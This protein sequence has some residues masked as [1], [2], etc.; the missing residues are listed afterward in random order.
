MKV[1]VSYFSGAVIIKYY[2]PEKLL[3]GR[4]CFGLWL[5]RVRVHHGAESV[6]NYKLQES[7]LNTEST[8][9]QHLQ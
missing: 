6:L 7:I 8:N 9:P 4:V 1:Y 5:L 3:E 2:V